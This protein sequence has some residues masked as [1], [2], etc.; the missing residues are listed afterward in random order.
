[1]VDKAVLETRLTEAED[2]MHKLVTGRQSVS[3]SHSQGGG[4]HS[5][6]YT[7]ANRNELAAYII[8]LK[9]QLGLVPARRPIR[10]R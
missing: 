1:M 10:F 5:I 2:A 4:S 3:L 6:G 7:Q 8:N 9:S